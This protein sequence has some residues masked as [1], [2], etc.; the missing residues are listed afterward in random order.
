VISEADIAILI[1]PP[2]MPG[3]VRA[4]RLL[5]DHDDVRWALITNRLGPGSD[6]T[7]ARLERELGRQISLELPCSALLRDCEDEGRVLVTPFSRWS[8][9]LWRLADGIFG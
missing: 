3:V 7:R 6:L 5:E 1:I 9:R 8:R 4:A 2:T